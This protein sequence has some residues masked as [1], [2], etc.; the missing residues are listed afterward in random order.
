M[1]LCAAKCCDDK[2]ASMDSV[3]GCIERCS[4]PVNR[5][6]QYLQKE[7]GDYQGRLQRC[8][9]VN[10]EMTSTKDVANKNIHLKI[11]YI[12]IQI[13]PEAGFFF[14]RF[15]NFVKITS[16]YRFKLLFLFASIFFPTA[17]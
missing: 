6:Q 2:N 1:H 5:A 9:M 11:G 10:N 12:L 15:F 4:T 14:F 8:V 7:L 17:M 3:H 16:G 13:Q